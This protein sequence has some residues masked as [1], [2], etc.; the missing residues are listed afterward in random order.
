[1]KTRRHAPHLSARLLWPIVP[2]IAHFHKMEIVTNLSF[3]AFCR[4]CVIFSLPGCKNAEISGFF[5]P[6]FPFLPSASPLPKAPAAPNSASLLHFV[7]NREIWALGRKPSACRPPPAPA[8]RSIGRSPFR[9]RRNKAGS[10]C[11][12]RLRR[13]G[14]ARRKPSTLCPHLTCRPG[15]PAPAGSGSRSRCR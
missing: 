3:Y 5:A 6:F 1:M 9:L 13:R 15:R 12:R 2:A 10:A 4:F 7:I 11:F 14:C 8:S